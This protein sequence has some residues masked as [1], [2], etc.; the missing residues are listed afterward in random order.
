[1][2]ILQRILKKVLG[3]RDDLRD[4]REAAKSASIKKGEN[5]V[6]KKKPKGGK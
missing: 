4:I 3:N 6:S 2:N 1:M 5:T